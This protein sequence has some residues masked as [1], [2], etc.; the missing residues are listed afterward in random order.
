VKKRRLFIIAFAVLLVGVFAIAALPV[1]KRCVQWVVR[2]LPELVYGGKP[3]SYWLARNPE[4]CPSSIATDPKAVPILIAALKDRH[5]SW[6]SLEYE[7]LWRKLPP[8]IRR[9]LRPPANPL[10]LEKKRQSAAIVL[11]SM[12]GLATPAIPGLIAAF[13]DSY[14]DVREAAIRSLT[15]LGQADPAVAKTLAAALLHKNALTRFYAALALRRL[16]Q[17]DETVMR[18]LT[19]PLKNPDPDVRAAQ[20]ARPGVYRSTGPAGHCST[21]CGFRG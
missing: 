8:W 14:L 4:A 12:A 13:N 18:E 1:A 7:A 2:P 6:L 21:G 9:H 11:G 5:E 20:G 19:A 10:D 15:R 3:L 16:G 17:R